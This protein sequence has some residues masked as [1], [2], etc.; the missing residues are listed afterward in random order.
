MARGRKISN[1]LLLASHPTIMCTIH[2]TINLSKEGQT[3]VAI[4]TSLHQLAHA[5]INK[6]YFLHLRKQARTHIL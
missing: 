3:F 2:T 5:G 4:P 1:I 6:N